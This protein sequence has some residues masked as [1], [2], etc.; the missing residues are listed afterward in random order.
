MPADAE[1]LGADFARQVARVVGRVL[2]AELLTAG[3]AALLLGYTKSGFAEARRT[4]GFPRP[5]KAPGCRRP[6][7]RRA[8]LLRW[9]ERL[10]PPSRRELIVE[11][12]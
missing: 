3:Q 8:E 2:V 1:A 7:Y 9:V 6:K 12:G 10:K 4:T 11:H 5:V